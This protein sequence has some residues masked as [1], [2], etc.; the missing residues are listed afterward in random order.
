MNRIATVL[1]MGLACS[2]AAA[3][4]APQ[5]SQP[6]AQKPGTAVIKPGNPDPG[7]NLSPPQTGTMPVVPPPGTAGNNPQIVPK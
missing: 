2:G 3:Q 4:P 1:I 5:S 6:P 7:I